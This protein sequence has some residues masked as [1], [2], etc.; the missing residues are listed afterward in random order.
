MRNQRRLASPFELSQ[1]RLIPGDDRPQLH[2]SS[3]SAHALRPVDDAFDSNLGRVS[4]EARHRDHRDHGEAQQE[5]SS[6]AEHAAG[7]RKD[8]SRGFL[9]GEPQADRGL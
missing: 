3:Q 4:R 7:L 1:S 6:T 9:L 2:P 8:D 5:S